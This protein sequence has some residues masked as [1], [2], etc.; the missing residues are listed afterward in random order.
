MYE[1]HQNYWILSLFSMLF[2]T[3]IEIFE[4]VDAVNDDLY[5]IKCIFINFIYQYP[6][7]CQEKLFK[8]NNI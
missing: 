7:K 2:G 3:K 4:V 5:I 1:N 6:M 8:S